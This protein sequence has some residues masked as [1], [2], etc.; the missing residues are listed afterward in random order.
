MACVSGG[1]DSVALLYLLL[2]TEDEL[3]LADVCACH[4]N[5]GIRGA[6]SDGDELFVRKLCA[7]LGVRL[8]CESAHMAQRQAPKGM[9]VETWARSERYDFFRRSA[10]ELGAVAA[11]AH[12]RNDVAETVLLNLARGAGLE[13]AGGIPPKREGIIR[14]LIDIDR[15]EI[16]SYLKSKGAEYVTDETNLSDDYSRNR[17]RH[18]VLPALETVNAAAVRNIARFAARARQADEYLASLAEGAIASAKIDDNTYLISPLAVLD[19]LPR[20]LAV[21]KLLECH[22]R[23]V[24]ENSIA[25]AMRVLSGESAGLQLGDGCLLVREKD[26]I[27][28]TEPKE[29]LLPV[30][31]VPLHEGENTFCGGTVS[32][33]FFHTNKAGFQN[34]H[35]YDLINAA[36]Y[37]KIKGTLYIRSRREGD[38]F[39]SAARKHTKSL[40]KIMNERGIPPWRRNAVAVVCDDE[41]IVFV[42]GEGVALRCALG[43][44][45]TKVIYFDCRQTDGEADL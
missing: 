11:T 33:E 43:E 44:R 13:G 23:D 2:E 31:P 26:M 9:S 12:N 32:V 37:A 29:P 45:E 39:A 38:T 16:E 7:K 6:S 4:F 30:D 1:A 15:G 35:N 3:G 19:E 21:K 40:K 27:K 42:A 10:L 8:L 22:R 20:T 17:I 24:G 18:S 14:P 34:V 25:P 5:H 36:D 28:F 41:G